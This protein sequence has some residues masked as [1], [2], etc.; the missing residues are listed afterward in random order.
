MS[1]LQEQNIR[2]DCHDCTMA[3]LPQFERAILQ[4]QGRTYTQSEVDKLVAEAR[5]K[6]HFSCCPRCSPGQAEYEEF[7]CSRRTELKSALRAASGDTFTRTYNFPTL[8]FGNG[9]YSCARCGSGMNRPCVHWEA[10]LDDESLDNEGHGTRHKPGV[11]RE[12]K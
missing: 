9:D 10:F 7:G 6:E 4:S 3:R 5:L 1:Y 12:A 2:C 11:E 8:T